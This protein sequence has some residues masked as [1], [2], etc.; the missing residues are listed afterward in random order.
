MVICII[1][2][3]VTYAP[4]FMVTLPYITVYKSPQIITSMLT[5]RKFT[6]IPSF[7]PMNCLFITRVGNLIDR[8]MKNNHTLC[9]RTLLSEI[10][11]QH[12]IEIW[13][14]RVGFK[15]WDFFTRQLE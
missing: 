7:A 5:G 14:E 13:Q 10:T 15:G 3:G 2:P 9:W 1:Y 4:G 11:E 12:T 8:Q 6:Y